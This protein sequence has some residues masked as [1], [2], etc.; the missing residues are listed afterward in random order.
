MASFKIKTRAERDAIRQARAAE[1][2]RLA[3]EADLA[4]AERQRLA[5]ERS[6]EIE[7]RGAERAAARLARQ[8]E[9]RQLAEQRRLDSILRARSFD[10]LTEYDEFQVLYHERFPD[11]LVPMM[12]AEFAAAASDLSDDDAVMLTF[13]GARPVAV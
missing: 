11:R 2:E 5:I 13:L 3:A 10:T 9:D 7:R 4:A 8:V 1:M 12:V 6:A